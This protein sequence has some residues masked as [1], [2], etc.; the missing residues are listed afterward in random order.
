MRRKRA[1]LFVGD[2]THPDGRRIRR[3]RRDEY[4]ELYRLRAKH[5]DVLMGCVQ[6]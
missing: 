2:W 6:A 4:A 3:I 5:R 1:G